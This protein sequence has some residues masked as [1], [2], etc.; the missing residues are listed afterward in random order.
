MAQNV[1]VAGASYSD[2][3]SVL[4]PKTGGGTA[5]FTDVSDTTAIAT[6]VLAG[7]Y[8]YNSVGEKVLGTGNIGQGVSIVT[9]QDSHG[10]DILTITGQDIYPH[11]WL[12]D[13]PELIAT[14]V[15]PDVALKNTSFATWTPSTTA[16]DILATRT[17]G[18]FVTTDFDTT[19]EY[20]IVWESKCPIITDSSATQKALPLYAAAVQLQTI[21]KRPSNLQNIS[22]DNFN[23]NACTGLFVSNFLKYY[24]TTTGTIT[25]SWAASSGI[26]FTVTAATFASSTA[27]NTTVTVKSPKVSAKC[28]TTYMSTANAALIDQTNTVISQTGYVYKIVQPGAIRGA[29][30]R[31]VD[32]VNGV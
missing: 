15:L 1:T 30:E 2:V 4:L 23:G 13:S 6:D 28:S 8:F 10:G 11:S 27:A 31:I 32:I 17:A 20:L 21:H 16:S 24:G 22:A 9:T 12:G 25:Y 19:S 14:F 26:Y 5:K 29:Q 18:T 3:P 7:R